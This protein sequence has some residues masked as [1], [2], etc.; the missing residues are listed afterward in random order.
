MG[1]TTLPVRLGTRFD[2][3]NGVTYDHQWAVGRFYGLDCRVEF[4]PADGLDLPREGER[5]TVGSF[6]LKVL[7]LPL[8]NFPQNYTVVHEKKN[9]LYTSS[10]IE[11]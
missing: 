8:G 9:L 10:K 1:E 11:T 4:R 6:P 2:H 5:C 7:V 3:T